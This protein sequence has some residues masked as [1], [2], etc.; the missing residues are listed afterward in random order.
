VKTF[1][2][3]LVVLGLGVAVTACASKAETKQEMLSS[4]GFKAVAPKTPAQVASF[5][6][7]PAHKLAKTTYKGEP[8][9]VYADPTNCGCVY[10]GDQDAYN[11]YSKKTAQA[12][13]TDAM[14]AA[15][16]HAAMTSMDDF[17]LP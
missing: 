7:L 5:K 6:S 12:K 13:A 3:I 9:W 15:N 8:A 17:S 16:A 14:E 1:W 10:I 2:S 4:S 11:V